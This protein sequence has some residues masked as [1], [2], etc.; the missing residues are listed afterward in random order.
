[1]DDQHLVLSQSLTRGIE[2]RRQIAEVMQAATPSQ[3]SGQLA[4]LSV[5]GHKLQVN[6]RMWLLQELD[7]RGLH[8]IMDHRA[9]YLVA[10]PPNVESS[11]VMDVVHDDSD[12]MQIQT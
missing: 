8:R 2:L 4:S 9:L 6:A 11:H 3:S 10:Q 7:V 1:L 12:V 5:G